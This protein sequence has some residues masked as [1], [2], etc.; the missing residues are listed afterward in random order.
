MRFS[1][2]LSL[3]SIFG[4]SLF[5][6]CE[7][8]SKDQLE[9]GEQ[10][11]PN[12]LFI[13]IDDLRPELG[14]FGADYIVSPNMDK[15]MA[16]GTIFK[17][18]YCNVPICGAS[19]ASLLTGRYP[20]VDRFISYDAR[21]DED[22]P[23]LTTLPEN[24][25]NNGYHAVSIGKI[26]HFPADNAD[27]WSEQPWRPDYPFQDDPE[28][29]IDWRNYQNQ[30]NASL[31]KSGYPAGDTGPAWEV[32]QAADTAYQDGKTTLGAL[33]KLD[34]L[35]A[36]NKPFFMGLGY[37]KPHLPFTAPKK[38]WDL[39]D[40]SEIPM[41]ANNQFPDSAP[42]HAWWNYNELR[43]YTNIPDDSASI[44]EEQARTLKHGYAACVSFID[45]QL[46]M[47]IDKLK[48]K[49]LYDNTIIVLWGDHGWNLGEHDLWCKHSCFDDAMRAPLF[50]KP[51]NSKS[52]TESEALV[53]FVD[54]YPTLCDLAS[55]PKPAHLDGKSMVPILKDPD[56]E[57][58]DHVFSRWMEG[59]AIITKNLNYTRYYNKQT[60]EFL[61][62]MLYDHSKDALETTNVAEDSDYS[63]DVASLT[64]ILEKHFE[65]RE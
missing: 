29:Q 46:G 38:Y 59:E 60:R 42:I 25:K 36:M 19:R 62:H 50:I 34:E 51:A 64:E 57:I 11:K 8:K 26:F 40:R 58:N 32:G 44:V 22:V 16:N 17:K 7:P 48:E 37:I 2:V 24:F 27:G 4:L 52:G 47:V 53:N 9:T 6:A 1:P 14:S 5:Y 45:A 3:I 21:V 63:K 54:I 12:I 15:L 20:K 23:D 10:Q 61:S 28:L 30:E 56:T 33:K 49:G 43:S 31:A 18:A 39:Y 13:A 65:D 41:P 35:A 55:L